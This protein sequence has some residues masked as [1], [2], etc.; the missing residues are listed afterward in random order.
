MGR[1]SV[2]LKPVEVMLRFKS[3]HLYLTSFFVI[4]GM[5]R[6]LQIAM[7]EN[8]SGSPTR[9]LYSDNFIRLVVLGWIVSFYVIIY[10][11]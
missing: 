5:M 10:R 6:Y 1:T 3:P 2:S 4:A 9:A 7:V 11:L 8:K